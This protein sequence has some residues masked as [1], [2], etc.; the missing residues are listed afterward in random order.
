MPRVIA[1]TGA[2]GFIGTALIYRLQSSGF[3]VRALYREASFA[4]RTQTESVRWIPGRLEDHDSLKRLLRGADTVIHC[5]GAVRGAEW[6]QFKEVNTDGVA[7]MVQ[8]AK[9]M[10]PSP[11][12]LLL[13]SLAAREPK[14]SHHA[15]S[16]RQGEETLRSEGSGLEWAILRPPAVYGPG[17]RE[18]APLLQLM[19]RGIAPQAS[20]PSSRFSMIYIDDLIGA[21]TALIRQKAWKRSI[22]ELHD[23]QPGGYNWREIVQAVSRLIA[24]PVYGFKIPRLLIISVAVLNLMVSRI[25]GY[26]PMLSPGKVRELT[27]DDWTCDNAAITAETGWQPHTNLEQGL[28]KTLVYL[29]L[30]AN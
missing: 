11:R 24:R 6:Q 22:F 18:I 15:A 8:A 29:G 2:T 1:L 17:D 28:K 9:R 14:L 26:A 10:H 30:I 16:K 27:H 12:F 7:R 20:P 25:M 13:S 5:A 19:G 4:K 3:Q 23:G 21:M